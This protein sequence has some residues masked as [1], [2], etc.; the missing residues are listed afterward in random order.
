M[1][2]FQ[3]DEVNYLVELLGNSVDKIEGRMRELCLLKFFKSASE[4]F[5]SNGSE[6]PK[7]NIRFLESNGM[8]FFVN[9]NM[10]NILRRI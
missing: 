5:S 3:H 6:R 4:E 2:H 7:M 1:R 10:A 9:P 8:I